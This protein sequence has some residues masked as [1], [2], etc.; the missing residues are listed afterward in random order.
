MAAPLRAIL[1]RKW[2]PSESLA[3]HL[4]RLAASAL[5]RCLPSFL[6]AVLLRQIER[7]QRSKQCKYM[8]R[9]LEECRR[10]A[11]PSPGGVFR[12]ELSSAL[13]GELRGGEEEA[14]LGGVGGGEGLEE[15]ERSDFGG[16]ERARP[17]R[18][19]VL[20][21]EGKMAVFL[22]ILEAVRLNLGSGYVGEE[23]GVSE[24]EKKGSKEREGID[25]HQQ[26]MK[27]MA[28]TVEAR[29]PGD[30]DLVR[31]AR[32]EHVLRWLLDRERDAVCLLIDGLYIRI[33]FDSIDFTSYTDYI[34]SSL[35]FRGVHFSFI[36]STSIPSI[37]NY[38]VAFLRL[39]SE[40]PSATVRGS[41]YSPTG[42]TRA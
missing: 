8:R 36:S 22:E 30:V 41:V 23:E 39:I 32:W 18:M 11:G 15:G 34:S 24:Q 20:S 21:T 2:A 1:S 4:L 29:H 33:P 12:G 28:L 37:C 42:S 9:A 16:W 25:V 6:L 38:T 5:F 3:C 10:L 17:L 13:T 31:L 19:F 35:S 26:I 14:Y 7:V 40:P 27:D